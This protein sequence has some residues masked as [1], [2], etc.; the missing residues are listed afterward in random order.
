MIV[1]HWFFFGG[2]GKGLLNSRH[3]YVKMI[4]LQN[5]MEK[6]RNDSITLFLLIC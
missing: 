1:S 2:G 3:N 5:V 4:S 6:I